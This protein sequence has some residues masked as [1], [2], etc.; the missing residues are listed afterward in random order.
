MCKR[1]AS[2]VN[3]LHTAA[4]DDAPRV[5]VGILV[6]SAAQ[7]KKAG[8]LHPVPCMSAAT[9]RALL[10]TMVGRHSDHQFPVGL[11]L[12][13]DAG[14]SDTAPTRSRFP[15]SHQERVL[16]GSPSYGRSA[17]VIS[18]PKKASSDSKAPGK[19]LPGLEPEPTLARTVMVTD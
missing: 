11:G 9:G 19:R 17:S 13:A 3:C 16:W 7:T 5:A 14:G 10:Q 2:R 12:L 4:S 15:K 8:L 1:V 6:M 18:K